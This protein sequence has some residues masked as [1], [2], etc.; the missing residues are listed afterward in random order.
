VAKRDFQA[1]QEL[2]PHLLSKIAKESGSARG[3]L[4]I[5]EQVAGPVICRHAQP[6]AWEGN[7]L[8]FTVREAL[9][10]KALEAQEGELRARFKQL[11]GKGAPG[12]LV[13][14]VAA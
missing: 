2:L 14:R 13:F 11:L 6:L 9:W 5:W 12:R 4:P 3:L 7:H 10:L 1:A 8:V